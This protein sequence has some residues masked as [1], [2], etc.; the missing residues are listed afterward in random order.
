MKVQGH[1]QVAQSFD[2]KSVAP[3][4]KS[5]VDT[6][7]DALALQDLSSFPRKNKKSGD[8]A[9]IPSHIFAD[10]VRPPTVMAKLPEPDERLIS[11]PQLVYCLALLNDSH[12]LDNILEPVARN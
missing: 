1:G 4:V 10:N 9:D 11:T 2:T 3:T 8:I 7:V 6:A 12:E 5:N